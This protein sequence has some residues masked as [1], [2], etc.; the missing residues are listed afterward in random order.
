MIKKVC[1]HEEKNFQGVEEGTAMCNPTV[2]DSLIFVMM[3]SR[4]NPQS[5]DVYQI[6]MTLSIEK[7][8]TECKCLP[9]LDLQLSLFRLLAILPTNS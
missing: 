2:L 7:N 8:S 4:L 3:S 6:I 5:E 9:Q 1:G